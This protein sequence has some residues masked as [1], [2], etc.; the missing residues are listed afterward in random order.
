VWD[1]LRHLLDG[2]PLSGILS[3]IAYKVK[4]I[5]VPFY[6]DKKVIKYGLY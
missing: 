3:H 2:V 5:S 1:Y 4:D 6:Y